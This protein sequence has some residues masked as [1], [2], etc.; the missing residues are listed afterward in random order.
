MVNAWSLP[1]LT[2]VA[3]DG[4]IEPLAPAE[5][6]MISGLATKLAL[7]VWLAPTVLKV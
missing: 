4:E 7:M 3:P 6:V 1:Q 5:A 2:V